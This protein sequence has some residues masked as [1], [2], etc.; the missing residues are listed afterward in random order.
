MTADSVYR[1]FWHPVAVADAVAESPVPVTLLDER[2]VVARLGGRVAVFRDL[3]IY[4]E[5]RCRS[6]GSTVRSSSAPIQSHFPWV[7]EGI[8]G[9]R[10]HPEF[11]A[12]S[13]ERYENELR[14]RWVD[15]SEVAGDK[16]ERIRRIDRPFTIHLLQT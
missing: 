13:I 12:V 10:D 2:L 3:C 15:R 8:L 5:R 9:D 6:G 16:P 14:Y 4:A 7:H 1:D 11:H